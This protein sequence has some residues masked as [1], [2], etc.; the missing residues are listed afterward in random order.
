MTTNSLNPQKLSGSELLARSLV[1]VILL[2]L[3]V[4]I[5]VVSWRSRRDNEDVIL[6]NARMP[7][8]GGWSPSDLTAQVG[9]PL[10]LQLT[11]GD[12][13]HG[14]AIGQSDNPEIEIMPGQVTETILV[15]NQ[16]GKYTFYCTRWCGPN[17][18]RMRGTIEVSGVE[19]LRPTQ[20]TP[21]YL[22]L[23]LDIDAPHLAEVT[24]EAKPSAVRGAALSASP[25]VQYMSLDYYR[26]HSPAQVWQDLRAEP[27]LM[28][29]SD[30]EVWDLVA[31]IW[32]SHTT[33]QKMEE[34][35]RLYANNCAA[36]HGE[37][38]AGDGVMADSLAQDEMSDHDNQS[39]L[40]G[41][42]T[43]A[44]A[45]FTAAASMMGA[46]PATLH[47]KILRGGMGTGMPYWGP[48]FSDAQIWSLVNFLWTFQ[49][50]YGG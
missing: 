23:G 39:T 4:P 3:L 6:I 20:N 50:D 26:S 43:T 48:I 36:C 14:F 22:E 34:A 41:H 47:G 13:V 8:S 40:S 32:S 42:T 16:P 27:S 49:F 12:V 33:Q 45:D 19:P 1:I 7:E 31:S 24:P 15:F 35:Q 2:G 30:P 38:G 28:P 10:R 44:P 9:Q 5:G 17:H 11:S 21:L 37:N 25:P 18:W 29:L 46:A